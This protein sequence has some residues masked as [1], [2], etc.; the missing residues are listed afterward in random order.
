MIKK[1]M[2]SG[3]KCDNHAQFAWACDF[4]IPR[5]AFPQ[6]HLRKRDQTGLIQ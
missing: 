6:F 1:I 2:I 4:H 3:F 5:V